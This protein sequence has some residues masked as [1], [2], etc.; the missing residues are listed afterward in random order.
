MISMFH[1]HRRA[2]CVAVVVGVLSVTG[3]G[4]KTIES[5]KPDNDSA[6]RAVETALGAWKSGKAL[7]TIAGAPAID[8]FDAR[9]RSA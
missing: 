7:G 6:R 3:C 4:G 1:R 2:F 9:W 5:Y 8:T